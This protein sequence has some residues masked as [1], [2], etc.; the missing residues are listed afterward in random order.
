MRLNA[1]SIITIAVVVIVVAAYFLAYPAVV[2][3][4]K[5]L[6]VYSAD[7]YVQESDYLIGSYHNAT[8]SYLN[9]AVGGGSFALAREIGQGNPAN[10]FISVALNSYE[11]SYLDSRYSGWAVAF[12]SDQLV[13]AYSNNSVSAAMKDSIVLFNEALHNPNVTNYREAFASLVSGNLKI[14]ISNASSDPAGLRGYISLEIAGYLFQNKSEQYYITEF[15]NNSDIVGSS[16][17]AEL[18]PSLQ[19][20]D[21]SFLFIYKSAAIS[22]GLGYISLES[23]LSF[24]EPSLSSFYSNFTYNCSGVQEPGSTIYLFISALGNNTM[25]SASVDFVSFVLNQSSTLTSF[26]LNPLQTQ[27]LFSN[28][29][30]P[31]QIQA[32]VTRGTIVHGG[33]L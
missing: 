12:A 6:V 4:R 31:S 15:Q 26:G 3:S 27:I 18:V 21:I 22:K 14:G 29:T 28:V 16:N 1:R 5:P 23:N 25:E 9:N 2:N 11:R 7:A 10:V 33:S 32:G 20:G 24:G 19:S 8:G 30:P 13:L 17:A